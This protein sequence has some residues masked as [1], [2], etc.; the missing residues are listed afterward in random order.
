MPHPSP[1][2]RKSPESKQMGHIY[3]QNGAHGRSHHSP[4]TLI[5]LVLQAS[6]PPDF[7]DPHSE[8]EAECWQKREIMKLNGLWRDP[9]VPSPQSPLHRQRWEQVC[10]SVHPS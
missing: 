5:S 1:I 3:R 9:K 4:W 6:F 2:G 10:P 8:A 7:D